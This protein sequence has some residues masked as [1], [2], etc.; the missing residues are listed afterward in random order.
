MFADIG[1]GQGLVNELS[2]ASGNEDRIGAAESV[3]S[4]LCAIGIAAILL[5]ISGLALAVGNDLAAFIGVRSPQ[6]VA[7]TNSAIMVYVTMFSFWLPFTLV[8]RVHVGFQEGFENAIWQTLAS[9]TSM[10]AQLIAIRLQGDLVT[11]VIC[12]CGVPALVGF[13]NGVY[14][15]RFQ[16]PWLMPRVALVRIDKLKSLLRTGLSL[17]WL[18]LIGTLS[19]QSDNIIIARHLGVDQV[20]DYS[21]VVRLF[22]VMGQLALMASSQLWG[23]YG[24]AYARRDLEWIRT[25][26]WTSNARTIGG[27]MAGSICLILFGQ[28]ALRWWTNDN[29]HVSIGLIVCIAIATVVTTMGYP[30]AIFLLSTNNLKFGAIVTPITA[31]ATFAAKIVF[32]QHMGPSGLA[33]GAA[34]PHLLLNSGP[35]F[36]YCRGLLTRLQ[37]EWQLPAEARS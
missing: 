14:L 37:R 28:Q 27:L 35:Q 33:L 11:L 7:E 8:S 16:K 17:F 19:L 31:I 21:V 10:G 24:E 3:S 5:L 32:V 4:A 12:L 9:V 20:A 26:L 13:A 6:V 22:N 29:V 15:F 2:K 34:I 25:A 1:V 36:A 23:A 30:C 18:Q